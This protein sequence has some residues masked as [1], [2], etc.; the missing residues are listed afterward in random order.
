MIE[1]LIQ[2][3]V[4]EIHVVESIIYYSICVSRIHVYCVDHLTA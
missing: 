2:L 3:G 4:M 1:R